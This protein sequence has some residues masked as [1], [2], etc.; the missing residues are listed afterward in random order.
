MTQRPSRQPLSQW[1]SRFLSQP[2]DRAAVAVMALLSV[3]IV[4]MLLLGSQALPRVREFSW[5]N[6]MVDTDDV[7]F[8][9]T[10][11]QPMDPQSVEENLRIEPSLSGKFSWAGRRMA[12]TLDMPAPYGETYEITLPNAQALNRKAGFEPFESEFETRDRVFA[13]IGAEG[14]QAGRLVLFNLTQKKKT[15]L[16]PEDQLVLDFLPYPERD[17]ILFSAVSAADDTNRTATAQLYSVTTGLA[18]PSARPIWKLWPQPD[19]AEAGVTELI[20]NNRDYQNLNFDLSPDGQTIVVQRVSQ[21]NPA[22][23]GQWVLQA[24]QP[25]RKLDTEPGGDFRI[26]PDSSSLLL[27]QGQGTAILSL[28]PVDEAKQADDSQSGTQ[29]ETLIDFLPN[30]GLTL[31]IARDGSSAALVNF[32]QDDPE[33]RFTQTLFLVS[34]QGEEKPLLDTDG[35]IISAQFD[36]DGKLLYSLITQVVPDEEADNETPD[37]SGS[38]EDPYINVYEESYRASSYLAAVNVDT[39]E[40]QKLIE[41]PPQSEITID[42][43]PDGLAILFDEAITEEA[44]PSDHTEPTHRLWLLPLFSTLEERRAGTPVSL[45]PTSLDIAGR[46]PIWLP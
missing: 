16:T 38:P 20:L 7:A 3:V 34:N 21:N 37:E 27:Q 5:Q 18:E 24:G 12:Y 31:D 4:V 45:A 39:G 36:Q 40:A 29:S 2:L 46:H 8:L 6:Q 1:S 32:N 17:R 33:R 28:E 10:F 30:Y 14:D 19:A 22:D 25:P 13:Y 11:S 44:G 9:L 26:A 23:F 43:A 41:L 42:L 35:S 15:L